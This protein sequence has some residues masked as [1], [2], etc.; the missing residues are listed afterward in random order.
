MHA[1]QRMSNATVPK[2]CLSGPSRSERRAGFS[3]ASV[4][5][6]GKPFAKLTDEEYLGL[7]AM[8]VAPDNYSLATHPNENHERG[9]RIERLMATECEP[10]GVGDVEYGTR[11]K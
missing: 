5:Y 9:E 1:S 11:A 10:V 8:I 6:F 2:H 7:V 4:V 3:D